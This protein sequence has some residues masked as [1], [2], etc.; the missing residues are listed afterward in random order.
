MPVSQQAWLSS[1]LYTTNPTSGKKEIK[2]NPQ[3]WFYPP[4]PPQVHSSPPASPDVYFQ[5]PFFLWAPQ[6]VWGLDLR[7]NAECQAKQQENK[8]KVCTPALTY[9]ISYFYIAYSQMF[10]KFEFFDTG[11]PNSSRAVPNHTQSPRH[12]PMVFHG[13]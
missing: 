13:H 4:Q 9:I 3:M 5:V 11:L 2:P 6:R 10:K 1:M 12:R 8:V 7:C